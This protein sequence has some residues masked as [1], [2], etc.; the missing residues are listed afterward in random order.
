[1]F[2]F[3]F[4][5][6]PN[7]FPHIVLGDARRW[8]QRGQIGQLIDAAPRKQLYR[9]VHPTFHRRTTTAGR[10]TTPEKDVAPAAINLV[11]VIWYIIQLNAA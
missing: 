11:G 10:R 3:F 6:S 7:P 2:F 9:R 1:V 8:G 5:W 4:C